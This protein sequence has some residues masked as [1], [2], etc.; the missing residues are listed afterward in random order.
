MPPSPQSCFLSPAEKKANHRC[1]SGR[2]KERV[3]NPAHEGITWR[4]GRWG[5]GGSCQNRSETPPR[6]Q[7]KG[8]GLPTGGEMAFRCHVNK[9]RAAWSWAGGRL[10]LPRTG[11][12]PATRLAALVG[13]ARGG[14]CFSWPTWVGKAEMV[15]PETGPPAGRSCPKTQRAETTPPPSCPLCNQEGLG[16]VWGSWGWEWPLRSAPGVL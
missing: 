4:G 16:H 8:S 2:S 15:S 1:G 10:C 6:K 14:V 7:E 13:P 9:A 12:T 3:S 11:L 5:G